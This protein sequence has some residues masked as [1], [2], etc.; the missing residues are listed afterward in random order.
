MEGYRFSLFWQ[1]MN[2]SK[3]ES[4]MKPAHEKGG[5]VLL[6]FLP[7]LGIGAQQILDELV[8]LHVV[9]ADAE[10]LEVPLFG[11]PFLLPVSSDRP[12]I[13]VMLDAVDLEGDN[14]FFLLVISNHF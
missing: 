11:Q 12:W 9:I 13:V 5:K 14:R 1:S 4:V 6:F 2:V 7:L 10:E 3:E 8:V